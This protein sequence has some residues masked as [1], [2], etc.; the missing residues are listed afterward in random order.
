MSVVIV[1]CIRK[2]KHTD[3]GKVAVSLGKAQ[4]R[5]ADEETYPGK[6]KGDERPKAILKFDCVVRL[7]ML[8]QNV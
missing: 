7:P 5:V 6:D 8:R 4:R 1:R 3:P 2:D